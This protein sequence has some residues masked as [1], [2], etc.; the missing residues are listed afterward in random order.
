M[1]VTGTVALMPASATVVFGSTNDTE[2]SVTAHGSAAGVGVPGGEALMRPK[3]E[4]LAPPGGTP[5]RYE[6]PSRSPE[7]SV[8]VVASVWP[9]LLFPKSQ[10]LTPSVR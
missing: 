4:L 2:A 5:Y 10:P 3:Q 9:V 1:T 8:Q 6:R 7:V